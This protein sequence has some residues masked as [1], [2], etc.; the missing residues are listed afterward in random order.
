MLKPILSIS[1]LC[2]AVACGSTNPFDAEEGDGG[3]SGS[4]TGGDNSGI[5]SDGLPPGTTSPTPDTGI[6]RSEPT[7]AGDAARYGNG[8]AHSI[9]YNAAS[10]TFFVDGL[11]FDGDQ[12]NGTP[13]TRAVPGNLR[14]YALYEAP[15]S[16]PDFLDND[17][18]AQFTHRALYGVSPTGDTQFA[19]IR[20]GN[21]VEYGFGGFVYQRDGGVVLPT[22]GQA[23]YSGDYGGLRDFNGQGGLEYVTGDIQIDVDFSGFN[24]NCTGNAC[25]NAIRGYVHNR[26]IF[27]LDGSDRTSDYVAALNEDLPAGVAPAT[28][29]PVIRFVIGPSVMD[30]NGEAT[31]EAI[32]T[33][34]EGNPLDTGNYYVVMSGDHTAAPGGEIVGIIVIE[35]GDPRYQN[36]DVEVRETGGFIATR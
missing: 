8:F 7:Q 20:T 1:A 14:S 11:A 27:G 5:S 36:L 33:D 22:Q 23:T 12:P 24:G 25:A 13:Y 34:P 3:D 29:M 9:A 32:T 21:Y 30:A 15:A 6:V 2:L 26:N 19:I 35:G 31:G 28:G 18:I 4:G 17:P 10:D 16:H